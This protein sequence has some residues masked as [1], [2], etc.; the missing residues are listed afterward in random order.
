M[1]HSLVFCNNFVP[2][3]KTC[4]SFVF[5]VCPPFSMLHAIDNL[6]SNQ[7]CLKTSIQNLI[8]RLHFRLAGNLFDFFGRRP[9]PCT[10]QSQTNK[11]CWCLLNFSRGRGKEGWV[12]MCLCQLYSTCLSICPQFRN[13]NARGAIASKSKDTYTH[14]SVIL[15]YLCPLYC[16]QINCNCG[17]P[18]TGQ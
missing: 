13:L 6:S 2:T 9:I 1:A 14:L 5:K 3:F 18:K 17:F 10:S 16:Y 7:T 4:L 8:S 12:S 15:M 11:C